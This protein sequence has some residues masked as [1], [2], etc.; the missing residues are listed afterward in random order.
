[1]ETIL[2]EIRLFAFGFE[3]N[4]WAPC[5]GQLLPISQNTAL[6][7][8]LLSN[9]GGDGKLTFALPDLRETAPAKTRYHIAVAGVFPVRE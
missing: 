3:L 9:F 4:G 6:F 1:M 8:L 2:G 5:E 7:S